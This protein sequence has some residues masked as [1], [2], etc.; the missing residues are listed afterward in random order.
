MTIAAARWRVQSTAVSVSV[1]GGR[2]CALADDDGARVARETNRK[3]EGVSLSVGGSREIRPPQF[4]PRDYRCPSTNGH[5]SPRA[6]RCEYTVRDFQEVGNSQLGL[7]E[8]IK[9]G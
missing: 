7:K 9:E 5:F 8:K 4:G 1:S 3:R 2:G 6:L